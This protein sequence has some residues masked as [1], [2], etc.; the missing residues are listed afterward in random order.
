MLDGYNHASRFIQI[1][2]SR[3]YD[4]P[5]IIDLNLLLIVLLG[6][7]QKHVALAQEFGW[8]G[9]LSAKVKISGIWRTIPFFDA[10]HVLDDFAH[11]G[12]PLA[13][14]DTITINAGASAGS[15]IELPAPQDEDTEAH[16]VM[17]A[18]RLFIYV[19][20]SL[21][22]ALG[23]NPEDE[24]FDFGSPVSSFLEAGQRTLEVQKRRMNLS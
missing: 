6:I 2:R 12:I 23:A 1:C 9:S 3:G 10:A 22:V 17:T 19:A 21:G 20:K 24:D 15:Y 11:H 4:S 18:I 8:R 5:T 16:R 13:L 14:K 7:G